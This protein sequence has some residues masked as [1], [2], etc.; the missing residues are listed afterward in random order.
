MN[1]PYLS[2]RQSNIKRF[3]EKFMGKYIMISLILPIE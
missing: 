2:N 3:K 1:E